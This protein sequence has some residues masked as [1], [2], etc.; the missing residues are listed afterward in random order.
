[1]SKQKTKQAAADKVIVA[2]NMLNT[3]L[4]L[5]KTVWPPALAD[6]NTP[7]GGQVFDWVSPATGDA[8]VSWVATA[9]RYDKFLWQDSSAGLAHCKA[10][11]DVVDDM[12]PM[13]V[14]VDGVLD[15]LNR[16]VKVEDDYGLWAFYLDMRVAT[17]LTADAAGTP[18]ENRGA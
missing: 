2:W 10:R 14:D 3:A 5:D 17:V 9:K 18:L 13:L 8:F 16:T 15:A 12:V 11:R 1:M 7:A 4:Y 6:L